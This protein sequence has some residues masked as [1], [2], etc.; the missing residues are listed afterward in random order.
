MY[1]TRSFDRCCAD[2]QECTALSYILDNLLLRE[3]TLRNTAEVVGVAVYC[4]YDTKILQNQ[5]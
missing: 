4:G 2:L 3:T 5:G 1:C